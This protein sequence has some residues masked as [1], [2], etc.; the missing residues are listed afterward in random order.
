MHVC[1]LYLFFPFIFN[2]VLIILYFI[3][4]FY[5]GEVSYLGYLWVGQHRGH[6]SY[7]FMVIKFSFFFA[8]YW[9]SFPWPRSYPSS[10]W[11]SF[12][13]ADPL[14]PYPYVDTLGSITL[15]AASP[16]EARLTPKYF[17]NI[18]FVVHHFPP[19]IYYCIFLVSGCNLWPHTY[20]GKLER[21]GS[22]VMGAR[23]GILEMRFRLFLPDLDHAKAY[24]SP[25]F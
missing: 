19:L 14:H 13:E 22:G 21:H 20:T 16:Q 18:L 6:G 11:T 23:S 7:Y 9:P 24:C 8:L 10:L 25:H 2:C 3:D 15:F 4:L 5:C 12:W 1:I 17:I